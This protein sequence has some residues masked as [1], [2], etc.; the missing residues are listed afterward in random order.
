MADV[1]PN[2]SILIRLPRTYMNM[3][4]AEANASLLSDQEKSE[5]ALK[6]VGQIGGRCLPMLLQRLKSRDSAFKTRLVQWL[7]LNHLL[8]PSMVPRS[9]AI[10]RGQAVTAIVKLGYSAKPI[11]PELALLAQD[12]DPQIKASAKYALDRLDPAEF[13]RLERLQS[14]KQ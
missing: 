8:S 1:M 13:S 7:V 12:T 6:V 3:T 4:V 14:G 10:M 9:A 5:K 11:F 2:G